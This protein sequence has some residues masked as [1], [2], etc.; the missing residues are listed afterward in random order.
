MLKLI[1][2]HTNR[3]SYYYL[4]LLNAKFQKGVLRHL[5]C[6]YYFTYIHYLLYIILYVINYIFI[7][8][9]TL[10]HYFIKCLCYSSLCEQPPLIWFLLSHAFI[11][12]LGVSQF[13]TYTVCC[14]KIAQAFVGRIAEMDELY[15]SFS[16]SHLKLLIS[17]A[18][19]MAL[20][21]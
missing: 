12:L 9:L 8:I 14:M 7:I 21:C 20:K 17:F 15:I 6:I 16:Y 10:L 19:E 18:L 4:F 3:K 1:E 2:L 5:C 13:S 11:S